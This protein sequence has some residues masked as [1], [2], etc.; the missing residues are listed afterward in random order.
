MSIYTPSF[1]L[2]AQSYLNAQVTMH[3]YQWCISCTFW[4]P[5]H[6]KGTFVIPL[7][8]APAV[9]SPQEPTKMNQAR[10]GARI[11]Q[12]LLPTN[13]PPSQ[14]RSTLPP[15]RCLPLHNPYL[16]MWTSSVSWHRANFSL[17]LIT[18][19]S[20]QYVTAKKHI[21]LPDHSFQW[22]NAPSGLGC[23]HL[24]M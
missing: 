10:K 21:M 20:L 24:S 13:S 1:H 7:G 17:L 14:A 18:V 16:E 23:K 9:A 22:P 6:N 19:S 3:Q 4:R 11:W 5:S 2:S 8:L 15:P 12:M